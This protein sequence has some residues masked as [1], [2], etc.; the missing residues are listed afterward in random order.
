MHASL[1]S[2]NKRNN[3]ILFSY[4]CLIALSTEIVK[5]FGEGFSLQSCETEKTETWFA[6]PACKWD[7][8]ALYATHKREKHQIHKWSSESFIIDADASHENDSPQSGFSQLLFFDFE[9]RQGSRNH[10]PNVC[11]DQ[12]EVNAIDKRGWPAGH[13]AGVFLLSYLFSTY[14]T[15]D[16]TVHLITQ[17]VSQRTT[18]QWLKH[19]QKKTLE[20]QAQSM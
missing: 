16:F 12:N 17:T 2:S 6:M 5:C 8:P 18:P 14:Y 7:S 15:H 4:I 9:R 1:I 13:R 10:E 20:K 11:I 19:K 3:R